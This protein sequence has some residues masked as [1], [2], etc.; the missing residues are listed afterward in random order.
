MN[1]LGK[2]QATMDRA[3]L[4][5]EGN[6]GK[7][8]VETGCAHTPGDWDGAGLSTV[9]FSRWAAEHD[10][11]F[12]SVDI[13]PAHIEA[14]RKMTTYPVNFECRDSVEYLTHRTDPI[15]LL[16]LD[17][18][19]YPYGRLLDA[20]GGKANLGAAIADLAL[21]SQT[22]ILARFGDIIRP[23]QAHAMREVWAALPL[24]TEHALVLIDDADLPGGGKARLAKGYLSDYGWRC[25]MD[26]YQTLWTR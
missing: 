7:R 22:E 4:L 23:S 11:S 1:V 12:T 15:D 17:S 19:D 21:T 16:Y 14:A 24:L 13:D 9:V 18:L 6:D 3:L 8:I 10:G 20:Y 5:L 26:G 2:R 25:V